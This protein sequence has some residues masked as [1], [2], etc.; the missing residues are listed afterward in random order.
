VW[1]PKFQN[2]RRHPAAHAAEATE[3]EHETQDEFR[4]ARR[5]SERRY[6]YVPLRAS[7]RS[8]GRSAVVLEVPKVILDLRSLD[9]QI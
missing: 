2:G 4:P 7:R 8:R 3:A 1:R 9:L 6:Q 5:G